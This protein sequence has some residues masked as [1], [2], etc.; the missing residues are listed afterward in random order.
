MACNA[1]KQQVERLPNFLLTG[2]PGTGKSTVATKLCRLVEATG[3]LGETPIHINVTD[4]VKSNPDR[5]AEGFDQKRDCHVI[6]ED[7]ILDYLEPIMKSGSVLLE[8]HSSEWFP[9]RWFSRVI[10]LQCATNV[11]YH[12]LKN[13]GYS[14]AK[15]QENVEAEIM[16][17]CTDEAACSYD[18]S[19]VHVFE[20]SSQQDLER[21][22]H[23]LSDWWRLRNVSADRPQPA[24]R[25]DNMGT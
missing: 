9:E 19:I 7:A 12:R 15:V 21:I 14:P 4:L 1:E 23:N 6:D 16:R 5:F 2:S 13:R 17:V 10:V 8:H 24:V 20:N 11:L 25:L 22:V 3:T 18:Q